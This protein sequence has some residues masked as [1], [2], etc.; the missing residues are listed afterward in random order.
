MYDAGLA[1]VLSA[2]NIVFMLENILDNARNLKSI[3]M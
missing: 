1:M 2:E 3:F